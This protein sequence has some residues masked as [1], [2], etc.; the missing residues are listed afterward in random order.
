MFTVLVDNDDDDET[1]AISVELNLVAPTKK[2]V[3]LPKSH[4]RVG[5][6]MLDRTSPSD[7]STVLLERETPISLKQSSPQLLVPLRT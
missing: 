7:V 3:H 4:A 2:H 6:K 1:P 5:I